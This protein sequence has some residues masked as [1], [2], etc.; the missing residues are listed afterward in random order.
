MRAPISINTRPQLSSFFSIENFLQNLSL[1]SY[2]FV[3]ESKRYYPKGRI[4]PDWA[5]GSAVHKIL[6]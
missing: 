4:R 2:F 5:P 3:M 6:F 1:F